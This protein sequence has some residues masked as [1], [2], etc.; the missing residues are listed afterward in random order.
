MSG[1]AHLTK[2]FAREFF[3]PTMP[4]F[5]QRDYPDLTGQVW[6]V[7]GATGGIGRECA[8]K[9]LQQNAKVWLIGHTPSKMDDVTSKFSQIV[10]TGQYETALINFED[11]TTVKSGLGPLLEKEEKIHGL[12]QCAGVMLK[13]NKTRSKQGIQLTLAINNVGPHLVQ[14]LLDPIIIATA[15]KDDC[16]PRVVWVSSM[17]SSVSPEGGFH[18]HNLSKGSDARTQYAVSKAAVYIQTVQWVMRHPGVKVL[19]LSVHPG[20]IDTDF[21]DDSS[22]VNAI[23]LRPLMR[24][25]S[26]ASYVPLFAA[27]SPKITLEDNGCYYVPPGEKQKVRN[28]IS[29]AAK[30]E[31]GE[32]LWNW[33]T[34][35]TNDYV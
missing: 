34:E 10:P 20:L 17:M 16:I 29:K 25:Q 24:Q 26:F 14:R 22:V 32:F 2:S 35:Q 1:L 3:S 8:L 9:L 7:V 18:K 33:L 13:S 4:S 6:V 21:E 15:E 5:R 23:F 19:S 11:L 12:L 31:K 30:G 27:L 28:D